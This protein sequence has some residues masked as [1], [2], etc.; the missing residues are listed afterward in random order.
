MEYR[1]FGDTIV[2]RLDPDEEICEKLAE[3]ADKE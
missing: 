1:R 2:L 3:V